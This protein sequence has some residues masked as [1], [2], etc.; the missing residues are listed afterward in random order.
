MGYWRGVAY[1]FSIAT[2][3]GGLAESYSAVYVTHQIVGIM[4]IVA[5]VFS[6]FL[7]RIIG[8]LDSIQYNLRYLANREKKVA[9]LEH[10]KNLSVV[11]E[12]KED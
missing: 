11:D 8:A 9:Q 6:T 5:G 1:F 2:I 7:I 12:E 10:E 3:I 4:L